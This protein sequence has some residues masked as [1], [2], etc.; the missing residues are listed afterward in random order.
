MKAFVSIRTSRSSKWKKSLIKNLAVENFVQFDIIQDLNWSLMNILDEICNNCDFKLAK[1]NITVQGLSEQIKEWQSWSDKWI[2]RNDKSY[3][4]ASN[5]IECSTTA[6]HYKYLIKFHQFECF[7]FL[8]LKIMSNHTWNIF[9]HK[10]NRSNSMFIQTGRKIRYSLSAAIFYWISQ[11]EDSR[12]QLNQ[13]KSKMWSTS[14]WII[15]H[16]K[17]RSN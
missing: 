15:G 5:L 2:Q 10:P 1:R 3:S 7:W 16:E 8:C 6:L 17:K 4:N 14:N 11:G 13:I 12:L 9:Q